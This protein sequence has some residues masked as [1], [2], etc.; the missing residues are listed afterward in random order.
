MRVALCISGQPRFFEKGFVYINNCIIKPFQ[1][2]VFMHIWYDKDHVGKPY[3]C[4]PW[5]NGISDNIKPHTM[6]A[7]KH[8]Y[9]PKLSI[10]EPEKFWDNNLQRSYESNKGRQ[11]S[12][13]TFSQFYSIMMAN[14]LKRQYERVNSFKYDWVIKIRTDWAIE[15]L[16]P[17]QQMARSSVYVPDNCP[18]P[19]YFNDQFAVG[20]SENI[21][22][23]SSVFPNIDNYWVHD[24]VRLVGETMA[25]HHLQVNKVSYIPLPIS[26]SIIRS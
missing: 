6:E 23:Y 14:E 4:A 13:I 1:P 10:F 26:H 20:T 22:V 15:T 8:I 9:N 21:D 25:T 24:G 19:K 2:D 3:S 11:Y 12:F 16:L 17:L 7:L 18:D 5:N